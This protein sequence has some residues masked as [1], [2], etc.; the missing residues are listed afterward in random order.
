MFIRRDLS[1][2]QQVVQACHSSIEA[3]KA[4]LCGLIDHP[5]VI[6][7]GIKGEPQLHSVAS[8]LDTNGVKYKKFHEPDIGNQLTSISTEPIYD[9]QRNK[10][11]KYQLLKGEC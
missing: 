7:C 10:F 2:P 6:V 3:S 11:K 9:D 4:F 8:W 1:Q 5:S